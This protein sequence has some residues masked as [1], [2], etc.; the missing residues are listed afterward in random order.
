MSMVKK[1]VRSIII[2]CLS[3]SFLN[4]QSSMDSLESLLPKVSATDK[5]EILNALAQAYWEID[6]DKTIE[7]GLQALNLARKLEDKKNEGD[8]LLNLCQG[9]LY[10]DV[11]DRALEYG[12]KSLEIRWQLGDSVDIA[13][14]LRTLGWLYYDIENPDLALEYHKKVLAIHEKLDDPEKIAYSYNSLGL[15][16]AQKGSH[17]TALSYYFK[18]LEIEE[19]LGNEERMA[20]ALNNIGISYAS[21]GKYELA[22]SYLTRSLDTKEQIGAGNLMAETLN[23]LADVYL[24]LER[25]DDAQLSLSRAMGIISEVS[26]NKVLLMDNY[27]ISSELYESLGDHQKSLEYYKLHSNIRNTI[28]SEEKSHNLSEMRLLYETEKRENEI[29]LLERERE[30]AEIKRL[31][32]TAGLI[33]LAIIAALIISRMRS[34]QRKNKQIFQ[35][36]KDLMEMKLDKASLEK[37]KLSNELNFKN[38]EL[39]TLAMHIAQRNEIFINFIASLKKIDQSNGDASTNIK[40]LIRSFEQKV[41]INHEL[42]DFYAHIETVNQDFFFKLH[43]RF[44]DLTQHEKRLASQLRLNLSSKDIASLNNISIKSVDMARYRL[45]KHLNL[46]AQENINEFLQNI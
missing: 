24:K 14:T 40:G 38:K 22:L 21:I 44:P 3:I 9:Y 18:A 6:P 41:K 42:E 12:L 31:A 39:T 33:L 15:V 8:A 2:F 17:Q 37:E 19:S 23:K 34:S 25:Y 35:A 11:Y 5:L 36:Q 46:E 28:L 16:Y 29:K 20:V 30:I 27:L 1:I 26:D 13:F 10:N 7:F 45:R 43:Q 4:G 32:L